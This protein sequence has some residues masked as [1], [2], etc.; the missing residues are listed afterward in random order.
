MGSDSKNID[1]AVVALTGTLL[2]DDG[3]ILEYIISSYHQKNNYFESFYILDFL[4]ENRFMY[5]AVKCDLLQLEN[6]IPFRVLEKLFNMITERL[7]QDGRQHYGLSVTELVLS[8][9][10]SDDL[11]GHHLAS[12]DYGGE[13]YDHIL[14]LLHSCYMASHAEPIRTMEDPGFNYSATQLDFAGVKRACF[15]IPPLT[16]TYST[17]PFLRNL[18]AFEQISSP[19]FRLLFIPQISSPKFRLFTSHPFLMGKLINSMEDVELLIKAGVINNRLS[20]SEEMLHLFNNICKNVHVSEF[21]SV[22]PW[23][24]VSHYCNRFWPRCIAKLRR[25][26]FGSPWTLI[27]VLAAFALFVLTFLHTLYTMRH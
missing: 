15:K 10:G 20:S 4:K 7:P 22:E 11:T 17:E 27:S 16:I 26:Y 24:L 21:Y 14:H 13:N 2:T 8:F 1:E 23:K 6:Q 3:F 12:I 25:D 18:I 5:L 9:F 19:Q